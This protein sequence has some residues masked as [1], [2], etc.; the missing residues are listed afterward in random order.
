MP[1]TTTHIGL[2]VIYGIVLLPVYLMIAGW[3]V[4]K[5]GDYRVVA[6]A[7]SYVIGFIGLVVGGLFALD[8]IITIVAS[9]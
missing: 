1:T 7:S 5:P 6:I 9:P 3:L 8:A 2:Y 4:G